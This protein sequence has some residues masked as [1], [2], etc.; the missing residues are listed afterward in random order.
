MRAVS[1]SVTTVKSTLAT[2]EPCE[3]DRLGRGRGHGHVGS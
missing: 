2:E 3:L 1:L